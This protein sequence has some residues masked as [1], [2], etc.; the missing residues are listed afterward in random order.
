M[1]L[2]LILRNITINNQLLK[3]ASLIFGYAF[4]IMLAQL[5][6]IELN[7]KVPL[8]FYG[9]QNNLKVDVQEDIE[10][11]LT[12]KRIDFYKLDMSKIAVHVNLDNIKENGKYNIKLLSENIFLHNKIKLLSYSP[13][14]LLIQVNPANEGTKEVK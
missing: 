4:W 2:N 8:S 11:H 5:Q 7:L 10:V 14:N 3:I 9:L 13:S 12:G 1:K 6:V